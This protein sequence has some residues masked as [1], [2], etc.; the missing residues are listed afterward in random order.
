[1][2]ATTD[3]RLVYYD[4]NVWVSYM[5]GRRDDYYQR[6]S[7]LVA[8]V[9]EGRKVAIVSHPVVI[10]TMHV[11]R[12]KFADRGGVTEAE[13]L[14]RDSLEA[15]QPDVDRFARVLRRMAAARKV[16]IPEHGMRMSDHY[17]ALL[18]K[19]SRYSG[20]FR[21]ISVCPYCGDG[22]VPRGHGNECP[23]CGAGRR[24]VR[25]YQY[26]ALGLVDMEHAYLARNAGAEA[27]YSS[28]TSFR[29]LEG[30]PDFAP[31]RFEIIPHPSKDDPSWRPQP[32]GAPD[33]PPPDGR[34][35]REGGGPP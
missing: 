6:C 13:V 21:R 9:E 15:T 20:Y 11:L 27:F 17:D 16:V 19:F 14:G 29:D 24:S 28:D 22:R 10:E 8:D 3:E 25:S 12:K 32:P 30:D 2:Y 31:M 1:M 7:R 23:S 4:T 26:K 35:P 18:G 34:P 5:L 33:G